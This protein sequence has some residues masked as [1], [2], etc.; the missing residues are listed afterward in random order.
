MKSA[1]APEKEKWK[2]R[3]LAALFVIGLWLMLAV[4]FDFY[5]DLNDDTAMKDILSGTYTGTPDGHAIQM[6]YPLGWGISLFYKI[7]PAIPWYGIFLCG[8]QFLALWAADCSLIRHVRRK[9]RKPAVL[10]LLTAAAGILFLYEWIFVQY[11]VTAGLLVCAALVRLYSGPDAGERGFF[12]YH[13]FTVALLVLA[14]FLRTE[15]MLLL[16]PFVCLAALCRAQRELKG[17]SPGNGA[18]AAA[19]N[20]DTSV[21]KNGAGGRKSGAQVIKGYVCVTAAT[22]LF[23]GLGLAADAAAYSSP[24][25]KAFRQFFDDRTS[26][27]DFYGL[28]SYEENQAFY[29]SI[30]LS[31]PEVTLLFNYNFDLDEEINTDTMH[32]IAEYA[33][34]HQETGPVRRLY[35][36]VYAYVYRFTHGQELIF[37]LLIVFSYFFLMKAA[38]FG[39]KPVLLGKLAAVFGVRTALWLFLLYRGRVPERITHPLYLIELAMLGLFFV[40]DTD[41]LQWKKYEKSAI[42]SLYLILFACT[43]FAHIQS[44]S[45]DYAGRE[46]INTQWRAF[47]EYCRER[48]PQ[49]YFLDVYSSV[50]YSEKMFADTSPAYRN[51]DLPG[52][53]CVKSPIALEKRRAA[54]F[55]SAQEAVLTG[56]A[57]FVTDRT[58]PERS[59][60][61]LIPYYREKG[62]EIALE[63]TDQCGSFSVF[64][65][66]GKDLPQ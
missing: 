42:L 37:D 43:A 55:E 2:D 39:K 36:S 27:Y 62:M 7:L 40:F 58:K 38:F 31:E 56:K 41:V 61:F 49:F 59:P 64:C 48:Q 34:S 3:G 25:W 11:T 17:S 63:E 4:C 47:R 12:R 66:I 50:A 51:F 45:A 33:A 21:I 8:C 28:P 30:G 10:F 6:L 53:W 60:D 1:L 57:F 29:E 9:Q 35:E 44:A 24:D 19:W 15:M 18:F 54:G 22:A 52:G 46:R 65:V 16:S 23:M 14:F 32:A 5:Y 20:N 13:M 26:V